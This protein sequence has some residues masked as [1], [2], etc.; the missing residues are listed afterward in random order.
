M[1]PLGNRGVKIATTEMMGNFGL[2]GNI[3]Q[4]SWKWDAYVSYAK[5]TQEFQSLNYI[6][7]ATIAPDFGCTTAPGAGSCT[8]IDIFNLSD[9]STQAILKSAEID[10]YSNTLYQ[11]KS[12]NVSVNGSLFSLP[13]GDAQL[14]VGL[15]DRKE[16]LNT[17]VDPL[18]NSTFSTPGGV[19][20]ISCPGPGSLCSSPSQGGYSVKEAYAE[21]FIPILKDL[22][23]VHALNVDLGD[24]YSKY[25]D[26]G[27][28]SNW[29][30]AVEY[31]PIEDL[32]LRATVSKVFRAPS[33]T[34]LYAGPSADAP[35]AVDP[36]A[37]N[38]QYASNPACQGFKV[39]LQSETQITAYSMGSVF[40]AEHGLSSAQLLPEHGK[41]FDYGFVYDPHFLPRLSVN[42]D[43]YRIVLDNLITSGFGFAQTVL[44]QCFNEGGPICSHIARNPDGSIKFVTEVAYNTGD[45]TAQGVDYGAHYKF[46]ATTWGAFAVGLDGSYVQRY[47]ISQGGFTQGLAGH[48]D[49]TYGNYA[50]NRGLLTVDWTKGP[51][52]AH[53]QTRYVGPIKIGYAD[54]SLG[55]SG[56]NTQG[57]GAYIPNPVGPVVPVPSVT[58]SSFSVG[59]NVAP[60]N[61]VIQVGVDNVFDRQ[62]PMMYLNNVLNANTDVNT[63]DAVGRYYHASVTVKF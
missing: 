17:Q 4:S 8:P 41:S 3:G 27:S 52:M 56:L 57:P 54:S 29:K 43:Y 45:L 33:P 15:S 42:A 38:P 7:I 39:P 58:T 49:K 61:T 11:M 30:V 46:P 5:L 26:V 14:A 16:Y 32:L 51:W 40:A 12:G 47:D 36:C 59:Y 2:K 19:P 24:R 31:R 25:S 48:F 13:A 35:V 53:W 44:N 1:T 20:T 62:P 60:I 34:D 63:Y 6:D 28:T 22:P 55:P 23:F 50:R 10:P 37:G 21:L 18:L 9:P